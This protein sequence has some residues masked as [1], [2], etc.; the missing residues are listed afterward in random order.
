MGGIRIAPRLECWLLNYLNSYE[1]NRDDLVAMHSPPSTK[2]PVPPFFVLLLFGSCRSRR[3]ESSA[4][5]P[6]CDSGFE[7]KQTKVG[8]IYAN[9]CTISRQLTAKQSLT[10]PKPKTTPTKTTPTKT[11]TKTQL[12]CLPTLIFFYSTRPSPP[13]SF[14]IEAE[15]TRILPMRLVSFLQF[16]FYHK[17]FLLESGTAARLDDG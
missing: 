15:P 5:R 12:S 14:Y 1:R 17:Q 3:W 4:S 10:R 6:A 16:L 11:P 9:N 2:L 13:P 7:G 8:Y